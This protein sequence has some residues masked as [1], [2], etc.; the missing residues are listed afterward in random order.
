VYDKIL[1]SLVSELETGSCSMSVEDWEQHVSGNGT[2]SSVWYISV[3]ICLCVT[4]PIC[5]EFHNLIFKVIDFYYCL[6]EQ[7]VS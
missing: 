2:N 4:F 7:R 3:Q 1:V 6:P 5:Y